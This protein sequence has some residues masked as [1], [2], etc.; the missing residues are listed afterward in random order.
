MIDL[1]IFTCEGRERLLQKTLESFK[2]C[3]DYPFN[4]VILAIDGNFDERTISQIKPD[5]V[6]KH[7]P[8]RGYVNSIARAVKMVDAPYFFWLEDDWHFHRKIDLTYQL[9]LLQTHPD[10]C[11]VLF[12]QWTPLKPELKVKPIKGRLYQTTFGFS[13]N[14]CLCKSEHIRAGFV[15]LQEAP[16]GSTLGEDG[17]ENFLT[18]YLDDKDIKSIIIDPGNEPAISHEGYLESTPRNWHMTNSL[19]EKTEEHLLTIPAPSF[20]RRLIMVGKLTV[21]F[22]VLS[23]KQLGSNEF[24]EFCFRII[25]NLKTMKKRGK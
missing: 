21:T 7:N 5:I 9:N 11:Q 1:L 6:I 3:C 2:Q 17:F 24:Y 13:A 4:R 12:S 19:E 15:E 23:I 22:I 25:A 20:A 16:K 8:R 10:W 18:R 14:P